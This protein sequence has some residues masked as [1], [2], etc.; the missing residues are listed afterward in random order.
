MAA[1]LVCAGFGVTLVGAGVVVQGESPAELAKDALA[2]E[3]N[4]FFFTRTMEP[5]VDPAI[6][7]FTDFVPFGVRHQL[8]RTRLQ[9]NRLRPAGR[10][11]NRG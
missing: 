3:P 10:A 6:G 11:D 8:W 4:D 5:G 9:D 2:Y 7:P 1:R